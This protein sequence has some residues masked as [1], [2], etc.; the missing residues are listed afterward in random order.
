VCNGCG[1]KDVDKEWWKIK[2][3][4]DGNQFCCHGLDFVNLQESDNYA[5]GKTYQR[6]D[7]LYL[8]IKTMK[9]ERYNKIVEYWITSDKPL[10]ELT[11]ALESLTMLRYLILKSK[12]RYHLKIG[13][14]MDDL[15]KAALEASIS[16]KLINQSFDY[17]ES[18]KPKKSY[19]KFN[20][21]YSTFKK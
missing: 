18:D 15:G 9:N 10:S 7:P 4:K 3:E 11:E 14:A 1:S 5:F 17:I 8:I 20:T 16:F 6:E 13:V 12:L 21:H 2:V 19:N